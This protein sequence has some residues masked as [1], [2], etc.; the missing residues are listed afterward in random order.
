MDQMVNINMVI[1]TSYTD[2]RTDPN[3]DGRTPNRE[4]VRGVP[5][6]LECYYD[7]CYYG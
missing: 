2:G 5:V 1:S 6:R 3:R 7:R 4:S